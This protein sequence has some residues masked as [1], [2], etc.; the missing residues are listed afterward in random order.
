MCT[1]RG[2]NVG[3]C[4]QVSSLLVAHQLKC[5]RSIL[6][7]GNLQMGRTPGVRVL[8]LLVS[9]GDRCVLHSTEEGS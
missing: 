9:E 1:E 6:E 7:S 3:A 5:V 8:L 2:V 4:D